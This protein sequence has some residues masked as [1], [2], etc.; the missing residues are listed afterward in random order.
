LLK[1]KNILTVF[2]LIVL[3]TPLGVW[4]KYQ[5]VILKYQNSVQ[6]RLSSTEAVTITLAKKDI[7]WVKK[8]KEIVYQNKMFDT[9]KIIEQNDSLVITGW[10]D[11]EET[12]A[13]SN[14][15][16]IK[17]EKKIIT[18]QLLQI[19]LLQYYNTANY[20][21][22]QFSNLLSSKIQYKIFDSKLQKGF[23]NNYKKP[24]IC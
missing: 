4:V 1:I 19:L 13:N 10:Y 14:F 6:Q 5:L 8:N 12:N 22:Y 7:H 16:K 23:L 2:L 11:D 15:N 24:P 21:G 18:N 17:K 3:F 9:K 20:N